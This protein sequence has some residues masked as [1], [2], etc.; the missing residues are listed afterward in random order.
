MGRA[1]TGGHSRPP[2]A[3]RLPCCRLERGFHRPRSEDTHI[4]RSIS[5]G[6]TGY[7]TFR[8]RA[9]AGALHPFL[10]HRVS[11]IFPPAGGGGVR[12]SFLE[13]AS[14]SRET[15]PRAAG[16]LPTHPLHGPGRRSP[17][18]NPSRSNHARRRA[19]G[20]WGASDKSRGIS[21]PIPYTKTTSDQRRRISLDAP[22]PVA[23]RPAS[24]AAGGAGGGC[25][26]AVPSNVLRIESIGR[27]LPRRGEACLA[28]PA[29]TAPH[30]VAGE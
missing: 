24:P 28:R 5:N 18:P 3:A 25:R 14:Q 4:T 20:E 17:A 23:A 1:R 27:A 29:D 6:N 16:N 21:L 22:S 11:R 26:S 8:R 19:A 30:P 13:T 15:A 9:T 7:G 10:P 2:P 12:R